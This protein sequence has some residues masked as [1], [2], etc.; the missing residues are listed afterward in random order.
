[1]TLNLQS[2]YSKRY[3]CYL[4]S[5]QDTG[6]RIDKI[7]DLHRKLECPESYKNFANFKKYVLDVAQN[8]INE[9]T[10]I[11]FQYEVQKSGK[12]VVCLK[13]Y[14]QSKNKP[15][16]ALKEIAVGSNPLIDEVKS[17]IKEDIGETSIKTILKESN[18]NIDLIKEK[19][20]LLKRQKHV[21]D[22]VGGWLVTAIQN[23]DIK[24]TKNEQLSM[25]NNF[26][27]RPYDGS[28]GSMTLDEIESKLLGWDKIMNMQSV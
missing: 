16:T 18:N 24:N 11:S 5:F 23:K 6:W 3:Y 10:D 12:K 8:E 20:K 28:D 4:K 26:E 21:I 2:T 15:N 13:Y 27:Q 25:F 1:M 22:N 19:Y 14:V 9:T 7:E 17:I